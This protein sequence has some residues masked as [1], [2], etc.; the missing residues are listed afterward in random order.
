M[1]RIV[2]TGLGAVTPVGLT[3]R[4]TWDNL[5]AGR[6]GVGAI[7]SFDASHLPVRIAAEVK[8]FDPTLYMD[9]KVT[10]RMGRFAQFAVACSVMALADAG[11]SVTDGNAERIGVVINTG[12]GGLLETY[13]EGLVMARRGAGRVSPLFIPIM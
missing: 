2:V 11:L 1:D 8:G 6:S 7:T 5:L 12:G 13:E 3:A 10:R 9:R 4:E